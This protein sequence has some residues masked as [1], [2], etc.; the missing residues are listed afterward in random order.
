MQRKT[1]SPEQ[2]LSDASITQLEYNPDIFRTYFTSPFDQYKH[3]IGQA[4]VV[5]GHDTESEKDLEQ[6]ENMYRIRF[7][8]GEEITAWGHEVCELIETPETVTVPT[9]HIQVEWSPNFFGGDF[10]DVGQFV[11]IP[12]QQMVNLKN[13]RPKWNMDKVVKVLFESIT[14]RH[15]RHIVHFSLDDVYDKDGELIEE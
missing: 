9:S 5:L 14:G 1:D 2:A 11:Y 8:D 10:S 13:N 6:F 4:F 3:R 15:H 12:Y 7:E